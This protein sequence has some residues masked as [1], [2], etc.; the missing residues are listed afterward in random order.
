P[1]LGTG[2]RN[3]NCA[4]WSLRVQLPAIRLADSEPPLESGLLT[5]GGQGGRPLGNSANYAKSPTPIAVWRSLGLKL[6][7]WILQVY[8]AHDS[9][10]SAFL[11]A[12]GRLQQSPTSIGCLR[13]AR[14]VQ[15]WRSAAVLSECFLL[16]LLI[17]VL[18]ADPPLPM[19]I[20]FCQRTLPTKPKFPAQF[21]ATS[22]VQLQL[23]FRHGI[24][25]P[26][27]IAPTDPYAASRYNATLEYFTVS[28]FYN[29]V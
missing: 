10:V 11:S 28:Y 20:P 18:S 17:V 3:S 27:R 29:T 5:G 2:A 12:F 14:T 16:L 1:T 23:V 6:P 9:T 24:R 8:S 7:D 19:L 25:N 13:Y 26:I 15:R 21:A 22:L 4:R